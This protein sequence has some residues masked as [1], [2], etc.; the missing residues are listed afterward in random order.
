MELPVGVVLPVGVEL[1]VEEGVPVGESVGEA[2][3]VGDVDPDGGGEAES[4]GEVVVGVPVGRVDVGVDVVERAGA[5]AVL[6]VVA[7]AAVGVPAGG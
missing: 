6:A 2:A 7:P 3:D 5:G 4:D 1:P